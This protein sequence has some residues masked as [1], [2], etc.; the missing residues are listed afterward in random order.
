MSNIREFK[1][2]LLL[3]EESLKYSIKNENLG[4]KNLEE[5]NIDLSEHYL[6]LGKDY[7]SNYISLKK[8]AYKHIE[9]YME[10]INNDKLREYNSSFCLFKMDEDLQ[11]DSFCSK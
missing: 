9:K 5:G 1:N 2:A 4:I 10:Y 11:N 8:T 3:A 7:F 6:K